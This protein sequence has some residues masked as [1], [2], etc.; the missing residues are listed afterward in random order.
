MNKRANFDSKSL[1]MIGIN[2]LLAVILSAGLLFGLIAWLKHYT[3][4][5]IEV[6]VTDVRGMLVSDAEPLLA[7]QKLQMVVIDS[8]YSNKVPLGTIVDQDPIPHSHAKHGRTVYV[9]I[10]ASTKRQITMPNLQDISYRQAETTLRSMGLVVDSVY[11]YQPSAFRDLVLNI[12]SNGESILPGTKIAVGTKVKLVV[13]YGRGEAKVEVPIVTGMTLQD[14]RSL[15][16]HH[17]LT[18]G[19]IKY[20]EPQKEGM[21][22]YIYRQ[23]PAAGEQLV[24]GETVSIYLSADIEK[25]IKNIET[26]DSEEEEWF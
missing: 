19:S 15:L 3:Q 23:I 20:D 9:T 5:G 8:T 1:K 24:E 12:K 21:V 17:R 4:H 22:M 2:G 11:E 13:G 26:D 25:S 7:S 6:E 10:N 16:L 14:A 18:I